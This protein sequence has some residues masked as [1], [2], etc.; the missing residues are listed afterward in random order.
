ML[1]G[2]RL[3][4]IL[5]VGIAERGQLLVAV[6]RVVVEV[7]L[8]VERNHV[9]LLRDHQRIDLHDA[10]IARLVRLVRSGGEADEVGPGR[11]RR[12]A[13]GSLPGQGG[14]VRCL[15]LDL[16][17]GDDL[18]ARVVWP[19]VDGDPLVWEDEPRPARRVP[20]QITQI[21]LQSGRSEQLPVLSS[22]EAETRTPDRMLSD[23]RRRRGCSYRHHGDGKSHGHGY[24]DAHLHPYT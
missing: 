4:R 15:L 19:E 14:P 2:L 24:Y 9:A 21:R 7:D 1:L 13:G 5:F 23:R 20:V 12:M 6:E 17:G 11:W 3:T 16:G 8:G 18:G 22:R 10:G